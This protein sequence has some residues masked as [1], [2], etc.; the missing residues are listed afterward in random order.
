MV[1]IAP[2]L[3]QSISTIYKAGCHIEIMETGHFD[4]ADIT[5]D[6]LWWV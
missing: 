5:A 2:I 6:G 4:N 1:K 3:I